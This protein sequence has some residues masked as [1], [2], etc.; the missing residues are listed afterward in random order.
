MSMCCIC[1]GGS[2]GGSAGDSVIDSSGADCSLDT[3]TI[4]PFIDQ[5]VNINDST[6]IMWT[7]GPCIN[8][9]NGAEDQ[10]G[11]G[12]DSYTN[13]DWCGGSDDDDFTANTMCCACYDGL[14]SI[15]TSTNDPTDCGDYTW[16]VV[17]LSVPGL[18]VDLTS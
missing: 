2:T 13:L 8:T 4:E 11:S 9:D 16:E 14:E 1:N 3:L 18:I 6:T 7:D 17:P 12:C 15:V 10:T 5:N